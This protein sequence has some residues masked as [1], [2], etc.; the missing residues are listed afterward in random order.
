VVSAK[1]E[2][3]LFNKIFFSHRPWDGNFSL[4]LNEHVTGNTF[5]LQK[6]IHKI[7]NEFLSAFENV[8]II[9]FGINSIPYRIQNKYLAS[10]CSAYK[11][12]CIDLGI[13]A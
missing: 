2:I 3:K 5:V 7:S 12:P 11:S 13:S 8:R 9:N 4:Q 10:L 6:I 1:T